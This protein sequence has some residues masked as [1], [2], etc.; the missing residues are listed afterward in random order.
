ML[1]A[2]VAERAGTLVCFVKSKYAT[3]E[4]EEKALLLI[5]FTLPGKYTADK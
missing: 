1:K 3:P 5:V 2:L 4:H